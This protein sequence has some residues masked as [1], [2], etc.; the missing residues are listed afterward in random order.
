MARVLAAVNVWDLE[1]QTFVYCRQ[2]KTIAGST[3][4]GAKRNKGTAAD[5]ASGKDCLVLC[6]FQFQGD[7]VVIMERPTTTSLM[8]SIPQL[9]TPLQ[10]V[11][12]DTSI[13]GEADAAYLLLEDDAWVTRATEALALQLT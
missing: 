11:Y 12:I 5:A 1:L 6:A 8:T 7:V 9:I 10:P 13:S 3:G 4:A 2:K